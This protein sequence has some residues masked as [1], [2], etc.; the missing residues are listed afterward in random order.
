MMATNQRKKSNKLR[1]SR[2]HGWGSPKKHRGA[3][4]RGGVGNAGAGKKGQ[5]Q[6]IKKH[7]TGERIGSYGFKRPP[8]ILNNPRTINLCDIE[9]L[10]EK[11][12]PKT[13][14]DMS[15][16][17]YDKILGKGKLTAKL[18]ITAKQF[19]KNAIE[20]IKKAGGEAVIKESAKKET[21]HNRDTPKENSNTA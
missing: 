6:M 16:L 8:A 18:K 7:K 14:I 5:Q 17:G 1:G 2:T 15:K 3:G 4:S 9:K 21:N 11:G 19:S 13:E 12:K 20:K 10:A